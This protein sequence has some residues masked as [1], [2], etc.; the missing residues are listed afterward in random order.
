MVAVSSV[1]LVV[2]LP[3]DD[4]VLV[5]EVEANKTLQAEYNLQVA[6]FASKQLSLSF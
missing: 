4:D 1:E 6:I 3:T 5:A 2:P